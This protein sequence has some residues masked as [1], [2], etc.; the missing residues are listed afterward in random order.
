VDKNCRPNVNLLCNWGAV[1]L[2]FNFHHLIALSS[3]NHIYPLLLNS[4]KQCYINLAGQFFIDST[5]APVVFSFHKQMV[6]AFEDKDDG[7][8]VQIMTPCWAM[9]R[10]T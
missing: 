2:N 6:K 1:G 5:V 9:G 3:G 8:A 10:N 7:A 4:F